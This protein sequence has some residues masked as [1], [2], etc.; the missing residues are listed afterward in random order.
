MNENDIAD[1]NDTALGLFL[2]DLLH[3]KPT[4]TGRVPTTW[5]DKTPMGLARTLRRVLTEKQ[6]NTGE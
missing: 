3:L 5:G 4:F 1:A 2:I 6:P